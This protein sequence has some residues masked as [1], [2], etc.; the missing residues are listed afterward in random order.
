[1]QVFVSGWPLPHWCWLSGA[2][3]KL[4]FNCLGF[5]ST[6]VHRA[7]FWI[8]MSWSLLIMYDYNVSE[9]YL[10]N[11]HVYFAIAF[12]IFQRKLFFLEIHFTLQLSVLLLGRF[13]LL[14]FE[15][16]FL[17][18]MVLD[19]FCFFGVGVLAFIPGV[20]CF[21]MMSLACLYIFRC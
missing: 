2:Y 11:Y 5:Y 4:K 19:F 6:V 21:S 17:V 15:S 8:L 10:F 20:V 18:I 13:S 14:F 12:I 9:I 7:A 16:D 1:L 3:C